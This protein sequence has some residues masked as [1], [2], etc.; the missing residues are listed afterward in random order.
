[1]AIFYSPS[2]VQAMS[3]ICVILGS[4]S[5]TLGLG[6]PSAVSTPQTRVRVRRSTIMQHNPSAPKERVPLTAPGDIVLRL[7]L[8]LDAGLEGGK[9]HLCVYS[10]GYRELRMEDDEY[11]PYP[12]VGEHP[13][14]DGMRL[15]FEDSEN[16]RIISVMYTA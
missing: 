2:L 6:K 8:P 10:S 11:G 9:A 7:P 15:E 4:L 3:K 16:S 14:I 1:M 12:L 13:I 5:K